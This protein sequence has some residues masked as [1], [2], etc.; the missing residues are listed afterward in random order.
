MRA[1]VLAGLVALSLTGC[2]S[3][4]EELAAETGEVK[5]TNASM[6]DVD[7]LI[8]AARAKTAM[9]PGQWNTELR[10]ASVD[11]SGL[12]EASRGEQMEA[13]KGQEKSANGCRTAD[14]LK[15]FD[16]SNL[17]Q[18]AGSC[19][20]PRYIQSGGKLDVEVHCGEGAAKSVLIGTGTLSK[21]GYDVTIQQTTGTK[22]SAG[23][24]GLILHAKGSRTGNCIAKPKN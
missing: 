5:L 11:L 23:Y 3:A 6:K 1:Y 9:Q 18:V 4:D 10:V 20:F 16:I 8:K 2:Q 13:I 22:G 19:T 12:P 7:R 14:D 21:T 17:E 24:L 15:P